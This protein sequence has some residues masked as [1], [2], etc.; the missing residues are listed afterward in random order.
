MIAIGIVAHYDRYERATRLADVVGAEVIAVD[1]GGVGAGAN[2][3]VCYEWLAETN[4]PWSV[5]IEDDALPCKGFRDQL[6]QV[7]LSSPTNILSLYLGRT[8]PPHWQ[9][10]IAKVVGGDHHYLIGTELL[11]HVAVAIRTPMIP[12]MLHHL[13]TDNAYRLGKMPIDEA[14]GRY[15][16]ASGT[17]IG[18]SHPSIV[19][20]DA[21][22]PTVITRHLSQHKTESGTRTDRLPR[23]AWAFGVRNSWDREIVAPIPE[24]V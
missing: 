15:A 23:Q 17:R 9:P 4:A 12:S 8:R 24:P 19:N 18:Y 20:H 16:R 3:E 6:Q 5:I 22:L 13:R 14:V 11:H 2:H 10:S 1:R 21:S 7:L